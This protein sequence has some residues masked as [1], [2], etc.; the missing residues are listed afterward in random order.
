V[1]NRVQNFREVIGNVQ[2]GSDVRDEKLTMSNAVS[3]PM[4][5]HI[6]GFGAFL[7]DGVRGNADSTGIV[8]HEDLERFCLMESVTMPIAQVLSHMRMVGG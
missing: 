3:Y 5:A 8:A 7:L 2:V 1:S 6:N 4:K